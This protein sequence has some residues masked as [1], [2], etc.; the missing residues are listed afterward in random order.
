MI[1]D[2]SIFN[3]L[4]NRINHNRVDKSGLKSGRY[5][6]NFQVDRARP[7]RP[8]GSDG[9]GRAITVRVSAEPGNNIA[10]FNF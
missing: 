4:E 1:L 2:T 10:K 9:L 7:L 3:S 8:K 5:A 6:K